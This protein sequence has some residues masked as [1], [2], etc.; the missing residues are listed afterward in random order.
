MQ[1]HEDPGFAKLCTSAAA[2]AATQRI[3]TSEE[4]SCP[5]I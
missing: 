5:H 2:A 3:P 4:S 1:N